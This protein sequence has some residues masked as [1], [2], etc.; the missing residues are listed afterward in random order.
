MRTIQEIDAEI[1]RKNAEKERLLAERAAAEKIEGIKADP[2]KAARIIAVQELVKTG[3]TFLRNEWPAA[4]PES[5]AG[6][7]I[8]QFSRIK[9]LGE[10]FGLSETEVA[11]AE[12]AAETA[13]GKL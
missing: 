5:M 4:L 13:F 10:T 3:I 9:T 8:V 12:K 11:N 7:K 1:A 6:V 2:A